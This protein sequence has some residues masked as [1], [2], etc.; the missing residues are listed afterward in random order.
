MDTRVPRTA[1]V[2]QIATFT[3]ILVPALGCLALAVALRGSLE[4]EVESAARAE[5]LHSLIIDERIEH[6]I[7]YTRWAER[8][9]YLASREGAAP[10]AV[11]VVARPSNAAE[12]A[13][14]RRTSRPRRGVRKGTT[15][16]ELQKK[17]GNDPLCGLDF[18]TR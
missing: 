5:A 12:K 11:V 16:I 4:R 2:A 8:E 9:Q 10:A 18:Q 13:R 1:V 17:C 14:N 15:L 6:S 3:A 7:D